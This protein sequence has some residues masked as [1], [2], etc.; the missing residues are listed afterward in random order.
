METIKKYKFILLAIIVL[1]I[2]HLTKLQ[3]TTG[4]D[5]LWF[6][7]IAGGLTILSLLQERLNRIEKSE[8]AKRSR[9]RVTVTFSVFDGFKK[10]FSDVASDFKRENLNSGENIVSHLFIGLAL[11][12]LV[13]FLN[14]PYL[15]IVILINVAV[16]VFVGINIERIQVKF[17]E[18]KYSSRDIRWGLYGAIIGA[19]LFYFLLKYRVQL[20]I[21]EISGIIKVL[22]FILF[23]AW[24]FIS[25]SSNKKEID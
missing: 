21:V 2:N 19:L 11:S 9:L 10:F 17:Y 6:D 20:N 23:S 18:G 16:S 7:V 14:I 8:V 4:V 13:S 22:L 24:A 12:T 1:A 3:E 25:H 5:S 15:P